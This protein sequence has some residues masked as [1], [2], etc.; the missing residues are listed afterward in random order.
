MLESGAEILTRA[1]RVSS[2]IEKKE[3]IPEEEKLS[4]REIGWILQMAGCDIYGISSTAAFLN[5]LKSS[6]HPDHLHLY[7]LYASHYT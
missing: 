4:A 7:T 6:N 3:P 1:K 2:F 5:G